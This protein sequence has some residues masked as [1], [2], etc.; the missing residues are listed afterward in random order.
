MI[1]LVFVAGCVI[2]I[3]VTIA[4]YSTIIRAYEGTPVTL[5]QLE[6]RVPEG[7][8]ETVHRGAGE[9]DELVIY[10]GL[11]DTRDGRVIPYD[12]GPVNG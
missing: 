9:H 10:T 4:I 3:L 5:A 2:G 12:L 6:K 7:H 11:I 8:I 1:A